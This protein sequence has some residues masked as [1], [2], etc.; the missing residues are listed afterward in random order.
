MARRY[1]NTPHYDQPTEAELRAKSKNSMKKA[2]DK[3]K[4]LEP[5]VI[6]GRTITTSW[7]GTAW[8]KNLERYADYASRLPR[9]KRYVRSGTVLDLKI[10]EGQIQAKVQGTRKTPYNVKIHIATLQEG[11][12]QRI[13]DQCG[14]RPETMEALLSGEF[15]EEMKDLFLS[16]DGLFPAPNEISINCSCPDWAILCKHAAAVLYGIG[17]RF[18][19]DP[20]LFFKLRGIDVDRFIDVTIASHVDAM[21]E[22]ADDPSERILAVDSLE[23]LFGFDPEF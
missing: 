9:G 12:C 23:G 22:H 6:H 7:W 1:W 17:N 11:K 20:L 10:S 21:L 13:I 16:E 18:D 14:K 8:C 5:V 3:G 4:T 15:P 19:S 2:T